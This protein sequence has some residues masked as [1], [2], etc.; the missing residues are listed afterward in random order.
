[1]LCSPLQKIQTQTTNM[2]A[3]LVSISITK[4]DI[5]IIHIQTTTSLL[6]ILSGLLALFNSI[7]ALTAD[8]FEQKVTNK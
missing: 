5:H 3:R 4:H 7:D 6:S 1:M 2:M 8:S